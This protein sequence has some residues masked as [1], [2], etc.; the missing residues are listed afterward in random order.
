MAE[1]H[2]ASIPSS[3][4][5]DNSTLFQL[6]TLADI[7]EFGLSYN[8]SEPV[9]AIAGATLAA[10]VVQGLNATVT[11]MGKTKMT[12]QFG[13]Y[14]NF[15]SFFG[16]TNLTSL[17]GQ[18]G[19]NF[20][21]VPDYASTMTFELFTTAAPN[22]F[23]AVSDLQVRFL[24]HNGT[25]GNDSTPQPYPLFGNAKPEM[26]WTDF[27]SGMNK[28]AIGSQSEWCKA[29]GNTTGVCAAAAT[30]SS[31]SSNSQK[32]GN[33]ISTAV[34]GVIGAVVTLAVILGAEALIMLVGS[35]RLVRKNRLALAGTS[36]AGAESSSHG[37]PGPKA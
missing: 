4:I 7:H 16:L 11:S 17:P 29:C 3:D 8:N 32:G 34:G 10:E 26:S 31:S 35:L 28:F 14:N 15:Q 6:R 20:Y 21:G 2:N 30:S 12:V 37:Y 23:P 9:R 22:P 27:V 19:E 1:I 33:G 18:T 5:L 25:T 24:F 36:S 13:A